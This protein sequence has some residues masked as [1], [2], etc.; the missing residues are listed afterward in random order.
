[1]FVSMSEGKARPDKGGARDISRLTDDLF[2]DALR[3]RSGLSLAVLRQWNEIAGPALGNVTRPERIKWGR[4]PH[5]GE[6][7]APGTLVVAAGAAAALTLQH[8]TDQ[9]IER[10]NTVFGYRAIGRITIV[11]KPVDPPRPKASIELD[12]QA[13]DEVK[14]RTEP[15]EHEGL[16]D[17]L[18]RLGEALATRRKR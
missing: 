6:E 17:A 14:R 10:I 18:Q 7:P 12:P 4:R 1:M 5:A 9:L 13:R 16:R 15:I 8:E 3:R 2:S 11:Q